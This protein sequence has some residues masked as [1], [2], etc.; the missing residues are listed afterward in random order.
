MK[1]KIIC[2]CLNVSEEEIVDAIR[3]GAKSLKDIQKATKACT[4]H[5]CK[6]LN[7]SGKCCSA[8]ILKIIKRETG[9]EPNTGCCC[10]E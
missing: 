4:G 10:C 5:Q 8:D 1:N 3:N 2:Y 6:R 9:S 7:P